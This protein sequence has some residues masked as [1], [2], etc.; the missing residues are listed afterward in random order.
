M[1]AT[2]VRI[3]RALVTRLVA[4]TGTNPK[5]GHTVED[6]DVPGLRLV[7]YPSGRKVWSL[8]YRAAD[9]RQRR[10]VLGDATALLPDDARKL[11]RGL[12][13]DVARGQDPSEERTARREAPTV[14]DL[15]DRYIREHAVPHKKPSSVR[16]D[17]RNLRLHVLPALGRRKVRDVT[18]ADVEALQHAMVKTPGAANRTQALLSRMFTLA[19]RWGMR[20]QHSN[21]CHGIVRYRERQL[22]RD[23]SELELARLGQALAEDE[24]AG[25]NPVALAA[26][27]FLL[28]TGLRRGEVLSLWWSDVDEARALV[29]LRDSKTGARLVPLNGPALAVLS[30]LERRHDNAHV[31]AGS[32]PGQPLH[33]VNKPWYRVRLR[34]GLVGTRLHDLRHSFASHAAA[35]GLGLPVIGRLLGHRVSATTARYAQ[36]ADDPARR[37]TEAVGGEL[38]KALAAGA[39]A[40]GRVKP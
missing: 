25:G 31:F 29:Y 8:Y 35:G 19:E 34:A 6:L 30:S 24:Q 2:R 3:T 11:A 39:R 13:G 26:I 20:P 21:P 38:A 4:P 1:T 33:D 32:T 9:G 15:A 37:A 12:L 5:A 23:L 16:A 17:R 27:R 40:A 14:G 10:P 28:F 36:V 18:T 22:H 7:V